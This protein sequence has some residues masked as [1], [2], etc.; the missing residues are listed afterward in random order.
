MGWYCECLARDFKDIPDLGCGNAAV[1]LRVF[2]LVG[3]GSPWW[4]CR[5]QEELVHSVRKRLEDALMADM[6]A[7]V[8]EAAR[9]GAGH[10]DG[11]GPDDEDHTEAV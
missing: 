11:D 7:H 5:K 8:E 4:R 1:W 3:D 6:L 10:E 2:K 9:E